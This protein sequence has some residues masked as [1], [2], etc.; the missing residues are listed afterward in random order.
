MTAGTS[1][2]LVLAAGFKQERFSMVFVHGLET[3]FCFNVSNSLGINPFLVQ[4][5]PHSQVKLSSVR[6]SK[7]YKCPERSFGS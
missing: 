2:G 5:V 3:K 1:S 4:G 6:Q 7:I